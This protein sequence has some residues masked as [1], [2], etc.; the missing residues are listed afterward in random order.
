MFLKFLQRLRTR[1]V[2]HTNAAAEFSSVIVFAI[3]FRVMA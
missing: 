1:S 2:E 3:S